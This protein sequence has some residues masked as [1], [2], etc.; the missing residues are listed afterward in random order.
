MTVHQQRTPQPYVPAQPPKN[1]L[2]TTSLVMGIISLVLA[3]APFV[4]FVTYATSIVGIVTGALGRG[5]VKKGVATNGGAAMG[6]LITSVL[7]LVSV[8]LATVV[9]SSIMYAVASSDPSDL[10]TTQPSQAGKAKPDNEAAAGVGDKVTDGPMTFTVTK[11]RDGV[12]NIGGEL[13]E[14]AQGQYVIVHV[15]VTNDGNEPATFDSS[16]QSLFDTK[17]RQYSDA[18]EAIF[19]DESNSF[20]EEINPGNTVKGKLVYDMPKNATPDT[21]ELHGDMFSEGVTVS[22]E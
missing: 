5:R 6:G 8:I 10:P 3:W 9:Y 2:G 18:S 17:G 21:I 14:K 12:Q 15:T 19:L 11:V 4:G 22:L 7:G 1:G 16:S 13:G 20:L